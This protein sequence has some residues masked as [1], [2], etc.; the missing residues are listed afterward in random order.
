[1]AGHSMGRAV[2]E[3][4]PIQRGMETWT[5]G[6]RGYN[7]QHHQGL[8]R[9]PRQKDVVTG[10]FSNRISGAPPSH[11]CPCVFSTN[12]G[13][14][15]GATLGHSSKGSSTGTDWSW[16]RTLAS[17]SNPSSTSPPAVAPRSSPS[18]SGSGSLSTVW[19]AC[20]PSPFSASSSPSVPALS[21][22]PADQTG[23]AAGDNISPSGGGAGK[24]G[25]RPGESGEKGRLVLEV[26]AAA[27]GGCCAE[28][29]PRA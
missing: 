21:S 18:G 7:P 10:V 22:S 9:P 14:G 8:E 16:V 2:T 11:S 27:G 26:V 20:V 23:T 12:V 15:H 19:G 17:A 28:R 4:P 5:G 13:R 24:L 25:R 6:G 29:V 3:R 1:M